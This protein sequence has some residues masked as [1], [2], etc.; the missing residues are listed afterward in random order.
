MAIKNK[1]HT[2]LHYNLNITYFHWCPV[3][4]WIWLSAYVLAKERTFSPPQWNIWKRLQSHM[5]GILLLAKIFNYNFLLRELPFYVILFYCLLF[6][7]C[8]CTQA[9]LMKLCTSLEELPNYSQYMQAGLLFPL[10]PRYLSMLSVLLLGQVYLHWRVLE[11]GLLNSLLK[12]PL[13]SPASRWLCPSAIWCW[14]GSVQWTFRAF[15]LKTAVCWGRKQ[16]Y[17]G[18]ESEPT[19]YSCGLDI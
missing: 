10:N 13:C 6:G 16:C 19:Q 15:S 14:A 12:P 1:K 3:S 17:Q 7:F 9:E 18:D 4:W 8:M 2:G 11:E 5:T